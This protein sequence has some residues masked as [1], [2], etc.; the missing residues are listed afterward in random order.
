MFQRVVTQPLPGPLE[1]IQGG[2]LPVI[3][4]V[5]GLCI[6]IYVYLQ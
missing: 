1:L 4:G 2:P 5:I 3:S 6:Y